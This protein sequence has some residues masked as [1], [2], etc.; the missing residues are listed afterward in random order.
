MFPISGSEPTSR[1]GIEGLPAS[2]FDESLIAAFERVAATIPS[3]IALG[4]NLWEPTYGELNE[5]ANRLAHRL[6]A[7]GVASNARIAVLMSH[8]APL[9]AAVLGI[10]KAGATVVA[11]DPLDPVSRLRMLVGDAEPSLIVTDGQNGDLA[12]QCG[13]P[14]RGILNFPSET[15]IGPGQNPA[16]EIPPR[17]T[18][19]L[20]Y[21]SGTT[22]RP[23][24]VLQ[25]HRQFRRSA[26]AFGGAMQYTASDRVP[27]FSMVSTGFG[28]G[29]GL[30]GALLHGATLCPFSP[31]TRSIA[32]L[33]DWIIDRGL[34]V[35]VSSASLFRTL[36]KTIDA[37]LVFADVR[38]VMLHGEMVTADDFQTF[39][40]HFPRT[41]ILVHTLASSETANIA[42][43][44]WTHGDNVPPGSLPVGRFARDMDVLL[45]GD[46]GQPVAH[47]E[48]GE[49]AVR[50]R[51]LANGYWRDPELT[52]QRFSADLDDGGTRL[53]RTGDR[54]R[55]NA[56]GLLE[57]HG[58]NDDR[59][60]I[61]GYRIELLEVEAAFRRLPGIDRIA[62]VP[63]ARDN[64]E[65]VLVAFVV[66]T[67][68]ASW[69]ASR[70]RHAV[71]ANLP[72]HMV[73][74]RI[75]F[76]DSLPYNRSNKV[77][78]EAL[79]HYSLPVHAHPKSDAPR[80][81]TEM[82][83]AAIWAEV[84]EL[85][86]VGRDD[87]F[88]S[89]GGDSLIGAIVAAQVYA[90][91]GIELPL[92]TI[93]D[94]P[95]VATLAA[96]IDEHRRTDA[97][98][99]P[100]LVPVPRAAS[101]PMSLL[102]EAI[103]NHW[104]GRDDRA[105]LT[106]VRSYRITGALDIDILKDCLRYLVE[107]H[108]I[109]RTTFGLV[110]G[111]PA[112][113]IHQFAPPNLSFVDLTG[114]ADQESEADSIFRE[115]SS[116]EIDLEKLPIRRNVLI[117]IANDHY[118]LLRISH[119]LIIDGLGSQI[120]DAELAIL[121]EARLH[122]K[123]PPL[124]KAPPLQYA[125]YA[126][127]QRQV[128]RPDGPYFNEAI[129][130]WKSLLSNLPPAMRGQPFRWE[131]PRARLDPSEGVL[132]WKLQEPAAARLDEIARSTGVTHFTVRLAAF[133]ASIA[134][135]TGSPTVVIGTGFANR[136]RVE[137][138]SIV[139]PF[140]TPVH[141]VFSYDENKTFLEWLAIVRDL[142]FEAMTRAELPHDT[143]NRHL[144]ASGSELP[145]PQFYF[146]ISR[147]H[148]DQRFGGLVIR[149]EFWK[150]GTMP[151]GCTVFIDER[152][153]E[154]CRV[155]FDANTYDRKEMRAMLDRYLR[156]LEAAAREPELP[157]G[158]LLMGTHWEDA[159]AELL[160]G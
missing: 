107:R 85:P 73:P 46:D 101:M 14:G 94:H 39:R 121:Y 12:A 33:A 58:R 29:S 30:W 10:L 44:R 141:L 88:F 69:T 3:R 95:T 48:V 75:V 32:A 45:L 25:T 137:T 72:L 26:A 61:R 8:D 98:N 6:I 43:S 115:E 35:Y 153:P 22:G 80:T 148:S 60:K 100:P 89:L 27:L 125:D 123:E 52:A 67:S 135:A 92:A 157:I 11:L 109:Q 49:I 65:P 63:V 152:R 118:R 53:L 13:L 159:I 34:T 76:L 66:K 59:I 81:G 37:R 70:L 31:K 47:G 136:N 145:Q 131:L 96:F 140:L 132:R 93:A 143:I 138:Q 17:Q 126:V 55:I 77:D 146:A 19:F 97:A 74:S 155:N 102:Q 130:W 42:W 129:S 84:I 119:P 21:T 24:G 111:R 134:D 114:V 71:R 112:Q 147:D 103:W 4:S 18:A 5:T 144:Q 20:T 117:K 133:A 23:K 158:K 106:H 149:D 122:G 154:N 57:Y 7:R 120:L 2:D 90:A 150:V 105:G 142:V 28:A 86:D 160:G 15:A 83:L 108:E 82:L 40:R 104:R 68:S 79:R 151:S 113:I 51:Y 87:D 139:G 99:T 116:R 16:I 41:S 156:L 64:H 56:D 38:A 36:A 54:G 78:R 62:V 127:W 110:E 1:A 91:C 9:I 128:M 124:P 50:S